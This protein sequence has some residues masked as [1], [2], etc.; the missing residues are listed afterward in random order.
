MY[1]YSADDNGKSVE[2]DLGTPRMN[3]VQMW[4]YKDNTSQQI[5]V[6]S[7]IFPVIKQPDDGSFYRQSVVVPL[8]QDILN[9][10]TGG[11]VRILN[12]TESAQAAE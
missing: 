3:F 8:I 5:L 10:D 12:A 9:R 11:P 2:I 1:S 7:L 6:P 4:D